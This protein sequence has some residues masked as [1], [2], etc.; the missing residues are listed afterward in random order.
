MNI[1]VRQN[2][3]DHTMGQLT[4]A[5]IWT[6]KVDYSDR[7]DIA[8]EFINAFFDMYRDR[9]KALKYLSRYLDESDVSVLID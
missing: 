1:I 9:D 2:Q 6:I 8:H 7:D 5:D 3:S 4:I